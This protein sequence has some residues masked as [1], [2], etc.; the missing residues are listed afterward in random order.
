MVIV[1]SHNE[2]SR[3]QLRTLVLIRWVAIVGQMA[4]L[5]VVFYGLRFDLPLFATMITVLVSATVNL[6]AQFVGGSGGHELVIPAHR[7]GKS[8]SL[9]FPGVWD[10]LQSLCNRSCLVI[11]HL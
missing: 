10:R 6:V 4:T 5:L 1:P 2:T 11:V 3:V 7:F 9:A 8:K